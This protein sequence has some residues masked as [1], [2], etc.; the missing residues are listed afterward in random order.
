MRLIRLLGSILP[1]NREGKWPVWLQLMV[2]LM[3]EA[4]LALLV[5]A[6]SILVYSEEVTR[7]L[8]A[9]WLA[10]AMLQLL[11]AA[12][13]RALFAELQ[14]VVT[15]GGQVK[16]RCSTL[17]WTAMYCVSTLGIMLLSRAL[18]SAEL[19]AAA[20]IVHS[21]LGVALEVLLHGAL[22]GMV[23]I[24]CRNGAEGRGRA[25][26]LLAAQAALVLAMAVNSACS[27]QADLNQ[28][29]GE[30]GVPQV[31]A[32]QIVVYTPE[33]G[34]EAFD[35]GTGGVEV[36]VISTGEDAAI[37][38]EA[39]LGLTGEDGAYAMPVM[40]GT[41]PYEE[42][43]ARQEQMLPLNIALYLLQ[44]AGIFCVLRRWMFLRE[45]EETSCE[46]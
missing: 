32:P 15:F 10:S 41:D 35:F 37:D 44:T 11:V 45:P 30:D 27:A 23:F 3:I 34:V 12:A 26:L 25:G 24:L 43:L 31:T 8:N 14:R 4:V 20:P 33:E 16:P 28:L 7:L 18:W 9:G 17:P 36:R 46:A 39:L 13:L 40:D 5:Q 42:Y 2:F 1:R 19:P 22:A 38:V 21:L 6:C 29:F